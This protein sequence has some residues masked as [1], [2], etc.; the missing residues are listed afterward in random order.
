MYPF[1]GLLIL[2]SRYQISAKAVFCTRAC[3]IPHQKGFD[4][5]QPIY[6]NI[7]PNYDYTFTPR[8]MGF[9]GAMLQNEFRYMPFAGTRGEITFDFLPNDRRWDLAG[10]NH[11]R[12]MFGIKHFSGFLN[13]DLTFNIDYKRVKPHDYDYLSDIGSD[14]AHVTDNHL[15][16]TFRSAYNKEKYDV[17][18]ELRKYQKPFA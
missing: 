13:N 11:Q 1:F 16:Q 9:R 14:N 6:F 7:A 12:W 8:V 18:L 5:A 4:Y 3:L 17:S 2:I 15:V 10:D